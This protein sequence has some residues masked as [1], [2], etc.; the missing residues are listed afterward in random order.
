MTKSAKIGKINIY[1]DEVRQAGVFWLETPVFAPETG[2]AALLR[3]RGGG[4][5]P[6]KRPGFRRKQMKE[7]ILW[8]NTS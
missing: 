7:V 8:E 4:A 6:S 3:P 1:G 5:G 2:G